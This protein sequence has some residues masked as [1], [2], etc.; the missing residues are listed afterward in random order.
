M[1]NVTLPEIDKP[2]NST[3]SLTW[4]IPCN[5]NGRLRSFTGRFVGFRSGLEH[6]LDW[7]RTLESGEDIL[8]NY[9]L[10]EARLEPEFVYNVSIM[11]SVDDVVDQSDA[12]FLNFQSPAGSKL[13]MI[14]FVRLFHHFFFQFPSSTRRSTGA[15]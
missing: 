11:I 9:R 7:S 10:T 14:F 3:V 4:R 8:E 5:L 15:Q 2:Y 13:K 1:Y 6:T 12:T